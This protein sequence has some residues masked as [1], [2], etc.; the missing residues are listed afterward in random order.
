[1]RAPRLSAKVSGGWAKRL[2]RVRRVRYLLRRNG[3]LNN[4]SP[5]WYLGIGI[6]VDSCTQSSAR[7]T[8]PDRGQ[9]SQAGCSRDVAD[10]HHLPPAIFA[11]HVVGGYVRPP[12]GSFSAAA[13]WRGSSDPAY[14]NGGGALRWR[15][16]AYR[17]LSPQG[18][19]SECRGSNGHSVHSVTY[20]NGPSPLDYSELSAEIPPDAARGTA[21]RSPL[22][23]IHIMTV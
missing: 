11:C 19:M 13:T 7:G 4:S 1:M 12:E 5:R 20:L 22:V 18:G 8:G 6:P 3:T 14:G 15:S 21:G 16:P 23:D 17:T 9:Y 2:W 10:L